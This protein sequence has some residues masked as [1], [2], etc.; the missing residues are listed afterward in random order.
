MWFFPIVP[1]RGRLARVCM[2]KVF[3]SFGEIAVN[4]SRYAG[5]SDDNHDISGLILEKKV[6]F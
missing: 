5:V 6:C 3:F 2:G 1:S 4:V